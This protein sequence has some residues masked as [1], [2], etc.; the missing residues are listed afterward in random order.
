[1]IGVWGC[2]EPWVSSRWCGTASRRSM[3]LGRRWWR[4]LLARTR[5]VVWRA[6]WFASPIWPS[7]VSASIGY[8]GLRGTTL[9][10]GTAWGLHITIICCGCFQHTALRSHCLGWWWAFLSQIWMGT[11]VWLHLRWVP[12]LSG[13]FVLFLVTH[14]S[15]LSLIAKR[16]FLDLLSW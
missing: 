3:G 4:T 11:Q 12:N 16:E 15:T 13:Y 14:Y 2:S 6:W 5:L 8:G 7:S 1:M 9:S 10:S